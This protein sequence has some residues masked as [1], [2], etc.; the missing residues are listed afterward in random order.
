VRKVLQGTC[1][2]LEQPFFQALWLAGSGGA[3][4]S[5][6]AGGEEVKLDWKKVRR[7][8]HDIELYFPHRELN[9]SQRA[10][11]RAILSNDDLDRVT[12][13]QGPPGTG[14]TTVSVITM[15][16]KGCFD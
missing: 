4:A 8:E 11:V 15:N 16:V 10:A 14:K 2:L 5:G 1:T 9:R 13:V 7:A 3:D 12:L 6:G